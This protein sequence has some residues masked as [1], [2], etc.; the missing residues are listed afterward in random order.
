MF[1]YSDTP[2]A[3]WTGYFTSRANKKGEIRKGSSNM[4]AANQ[5]YSRAVIDEK[6]TNVDKYLKGYESMM[7]SLGIYQHHDA[8]TGTARQH[9]A[10]DY[11]RRLKISMTENGKVYA[12]EIGRQTGIGN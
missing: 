8:V 10:D 11:S 3:F 2:R 4:H 9:V 6:V 12:E 1:P 5:L 7:D